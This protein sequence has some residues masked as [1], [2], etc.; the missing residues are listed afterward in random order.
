MWTATLADKPE[1]FDALIEPIYKYAT[2]T[3][4]RVPLG[5][6]HEN[7]KADFDRIDAL[8]PRRTPPEKDAGFFGRLHT[9]TMGFF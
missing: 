5:D 9:M 4:D 7:H 1:D 2:E 8:P 6:W 3:T